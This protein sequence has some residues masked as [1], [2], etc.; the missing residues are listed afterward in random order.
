MIK[1]LLLLYLSLSL[2]SV[3]SKKYNNYIKSDPTIVIPGYGAE[4][5]VLGEKIS[6][7]LYRLKK[8]NFHLSKF[9]K[10]QELFSRVFNIKSNYRIYFKRIY[11]FEKKGIIIF[12]NDAIITGIM[13]LNSSR[14]TIESV[15]LEKGIESILFNYG[16]KDL[17]IIK[18][19]TGKIYSYL[20]YGIAFFDDD[21]DNTI[22]MYLVFKP[23]AK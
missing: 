23:Q 10:E 1:L 16:S 4:R 22:D 11:Y 18:N 9:S 8:N 2:N 13:G 20:N 7:A 12:S 3:D 21:I 14:V 19:S 5:I 15:N 6:S 17:H